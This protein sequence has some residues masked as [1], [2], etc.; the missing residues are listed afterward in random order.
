MQKEI[1][2]IIKKIRKNKGLT[3]D[4]LANR[5]GLSKG[6][7]SKLERGLKS[8]PISTLSKISMALGVEMSVFF[9]PQTIQPK[10]TIVRPEERSKI[11]RD[12]SSFG[13]YYESLA[14][15]FYHKS[16]EPFVMT[17]TPDP[18][19]LNTFSHE[20][21]E[22]IFVL[23]GRISF[24]YGQEVFVCEKGDCLYFDASTEHRGDCLDGEAK[25]LVVIVP[26]K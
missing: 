18:N 25:A 2:E 4:S 23:E 5:T 16:I 6:Y 12:G 14:R 20:G 9:S 19:E 10:L 1:G 11:T 3:L 15:D 13:Y 24:T 8:P 21:E 7:L 17:L 26:K 22:M